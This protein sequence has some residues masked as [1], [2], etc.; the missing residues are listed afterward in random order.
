MGRSELFVA[1]SL[2]FAVD[3]EGNYS[4]VRMLL[5]GFQM[6]GRRNAHL[7]PVREAKQVMKQEWFS[8][9]ILNEAFE[10]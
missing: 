3:F 6:M 10:K 8:I 1:R 5:P 2:R 4:W 7:P 9:L